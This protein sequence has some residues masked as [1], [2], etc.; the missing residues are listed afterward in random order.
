MKAFPWVLI[1]NLLE[2]MNYDGTPVKAPQASSRKIMPPTTQQSL[3]PSI[4]V[5]QLQMEVDDEESGS[6]DMEYEGEY[7]RAVIAR[8]EQYLNESSRARWDEHQKVLVTKQRQDALFRTAVSSLPQ[9]LR[10]GH[11]RVSERT[12]DSWTWCEFGRALCWRYGGGP[13]F[14]WVLLLEHR[15]CRT[16]EKVQKR[17]LILPPDSLLLFYAHC[18]RSTSSGISSSWRCLLIS[19]VQRQETRGI[20]RSWITEQLIKFRR[21]DPRNRATGAVAECPP[22]LPAL[23]RGHQYASGRSHHEHSSLPC[24]LSRAVVVP[25]EPAEQAPWMLVS[26]L[27]FI[28]SLVVNDNASRLLR[29]FG[30]WVLLQN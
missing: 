15:V 4:E 21:S 27:Q 14:L 8:M 3:Q 19:T 30:W 6:C 25:S 17:L 18:R 2:E 29:V 28:E 16:P 10:L 20:T 5:T 7:D 12:I 9:P 24:S 13:V 23:D 1:G 11:G 22:F 26:M